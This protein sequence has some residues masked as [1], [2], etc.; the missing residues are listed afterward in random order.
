MESHVRDR[1]E[2]FRTGGELPEPLDEAF[3]RAL[4]EALGGLERVTIQPE[5]ILR[6]LMGSGAPATV[7]DLRRRFD[8][9]LAR[10]TRGK[11]VEKVRIVIE[12]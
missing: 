12:W 11:D 6:V 3:L 4:A 1:L 2:T 8:E 7:E 9:L 10:V 5:D